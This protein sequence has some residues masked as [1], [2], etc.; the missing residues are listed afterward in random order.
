LKSQEKFPL[1]FAHDAQFPKYLKNQ[2]YQEIFY[3]I[4]FFYCFLFDKVSH[5][6]KNKIIQ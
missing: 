3:E 4:E 6:L 2:I 1:F 5:A